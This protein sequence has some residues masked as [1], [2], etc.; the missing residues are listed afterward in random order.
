[1]IFPGIA[2]TEVRNALSHKLEM[3]EQ[4]GLEKPRFFKK[5]VRFLGFSGF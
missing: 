1:V 2:P 3:G 4:T 5:K